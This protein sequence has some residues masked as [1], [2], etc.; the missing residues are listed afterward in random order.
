MTTLQG[1]P[2]YTRPV[3]ARSN[4]DYPATPT[5][6]AVVPAS[7]ATARAAVSLP[8]EATSSGG[9]GASP[10]TTARVQ[11]CLRASSASETTP[12]NG[13]GSATRHPVS[14][15]AGSSPGAAE[16]LGELQAMDAVLKEK[17]F[18]V[19]AVKGERAGT[20]ASLSDSEEK[21]KRTVRKNRLVQRSGSMHESMAPTMGL[22]TPS[23]SQ[24]ARLSKS[25]SMSAR[26]TLDTPRL[27]DPCT[28]ASVADVGKTPRS[29]V[30]KKSSNL[31][32]TPRWL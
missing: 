11:R 2:A 28:P 3:S 31:M 29:S 17:K 27:V 25:G 10:T 1:S 16:L 32:T 5:D 14:D 9:I 18:N 20:A 23:G 13:M 7:A 15:A 6:G 4:A 8:R 21:V 19:G 22:R 12:T 30:R 26:R 24:T